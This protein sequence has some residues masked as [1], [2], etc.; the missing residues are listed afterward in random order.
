M[1]QN[2]FWQRKTRPAGIYHLNIM[3]T[4]EQVE[5]LNIE[6]ASCSAKEIIAWAIVFFGVDKVALASSFGAEDQVLTDLLMKNSPRGHVFT[7]DTGRLPQETYDTMENT[8]KKY[9]LHFDVLCPDA[10]AVRQMVAE[11]GPNLF[12]E[13]IDNRKLCCNVRKLQ[14]LK[15]KL[16]SLS[17]WICGLRKEQSITRAH[18][19]I[20]EWDEAFGL[21]KINPLASWTEQQVWDYIKENDVPYNS[22]HDQHF[23]TIG[24]LPCTRAV[25]EGEDIRAGRW[26]WEEPESK[27]CGL[28][29]RDGKLVRKGA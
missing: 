6:L 17:A 15:I 23:P 21:V 12:Y 8:R 9:N 13:S 2:K 5:S 7:L 26:W 25:K 18:V 10:E 27:E 11:H 20:V 24:C 29:M 3:L 19:E 16:S 14:P 28:H 4:K 1:E 22:L